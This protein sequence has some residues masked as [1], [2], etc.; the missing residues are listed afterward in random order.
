MFLVGAQVFSVL[1]FATG[2]AK[3]LRPGDTGRALSAI[4]LPLGRP[5]ARVLGLAE[6][7]V[8]VGALLSG[9]PIW[10]LSQAALFGAFLVWVV[11]ARR[12]DVPMAS[13]GCLGRDD[14]PPYWGHVL[15][16][17]LAV[18]TSAGAAMAPSQLAGS[19]WGYL[20]VHITL[21]GVGALM[22]WWV[23][24]EGARLHGMVTGR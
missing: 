9:S 15:V 4:G 21:V 11:L 23:L 16:D 18:V 24:G 2:V 20:V 3:L 8:G 12:L 19:E 5:L 10:Y 22:A 1:L 13:C 14:T 17:G 7:V 6:M